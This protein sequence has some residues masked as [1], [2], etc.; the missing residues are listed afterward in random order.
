MEPI[1]AKLLRQL[2]RTLEGISRRIEASLDKNAESAPEGYKT[3]YRESQPQPPIV[4]HSTLE[5][6]VEAREYYRSEYSKTPGKKVLGAINKALEIGAIFIA[7]GIAI[8]T[9]KTLGQIKRQAD[10]AHEQIGIMQRQL[11]ATDRPWIVIANASLID[12]ISFYRRVDDGLPGAHVKVKVLVKNVG[13]S[14]AINVKMT[15]RLFFELPEETDVSIK[16]RERS[17]CADSKPSFTSPEFTLA[18]DQDSGNR[19]RVD[20]YEAIPGDSIFLTVDE[21]KWVNPAIAGCV[22]YRTPNSDSKL[23]HTG[24][25]YQFAVIRPGGFVPEYADRGFLIGKDFAAHQLRMLEHP[26]GFSDAN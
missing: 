14:I 25:V 10:S 1:N 11:E 26:F 22:T 6:P 23:H 18:P 5:L 4:V 13:R 8:L 21:A 3:A 20:D 16:E 19:L 15:S 2:L 12:G 24:F 9:Y 17:I 7:L